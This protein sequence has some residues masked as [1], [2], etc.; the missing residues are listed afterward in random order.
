MKQFRESLDEALTDFLG[1]TDAMRGTMAEHWALVKQWNVRTNLTA[2][3]S[4]EEAAWLHYRDSLEGLSLLLAPKMAETGV[5]FSRKSVREEDSCVDLHTFSKDFLRVLDIGSGAGYPGFVLAIASPENQF[6]LLEPRRKRASFLQVAANRLKLGNVSIACA[7]VEEFANA[8]FDKAVT[9][10]TFS[11]EADL[12]ASLCVL[13]PGGDLLAYRS[14]G[15]TL[16]EQRAFAHTYCL[17]G[18]AYGIEIFRKG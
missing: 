3:D 4:E 10:A 13:K 9:R 11:S 2:I 16:Q 18:K 12:Q 15:T 5:E 8:A 17:R 6:T 7:R 14:V 1:I